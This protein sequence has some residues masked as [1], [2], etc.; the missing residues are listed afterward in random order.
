VVEFVGRVADA[1][2][3]QTERMAFVAGWD[4]TRGALA[5]WS[6]RPQATLGPWAGVSF[7]IGIALLASTWFVARYLAPT[8]E[9]IVWS[10]NGPRSLGAALHIFGRNALV[11]LMHGF[12][13]VAGYM[14]TTSMPIVADG[15][16]GWQ[17]RLHLWARP[18]T[19]VFVLVMTITSFSFQ[20]WSLGG[21]APGIA[22]AYGMPVWKLLVLVAPHALLELT[23][24]FLPLGAWLVLARRSR[25]SQ[26]LAASIYATA[27]AVPLLAIASVVEEYVT[28][29][30]IHAVAK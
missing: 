1:V 3:M 22:L 28:P 4:D 26:L 18:F 11:L 9:W 8:P 2:A 7:A 13:C 23:A 29:M 25:Y 24:M 16:S 14:A 19:I 17:R 21:A 10:F 30:L 12:I 5:A 6:K 20:A 15:Y 27:L